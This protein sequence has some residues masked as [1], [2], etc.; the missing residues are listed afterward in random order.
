MKRPPWRK[1][2]LLVGMIHEVGLWLFYRACCH[3]Q[4]DSVFPTW[5]D[6]RERVSMILVSKTHPTPWIMP[7]TSSPTGR[8]F[9]QLL[10]IYLRMVCRSE[11]EL[12][13]LV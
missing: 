6:E 5:K 9:S 12:V 1:C 7:S 11:L 13:W 8:S 3:S 10:H 2:F 4:F